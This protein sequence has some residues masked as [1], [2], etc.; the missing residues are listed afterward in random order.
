MKQF[1]LGFIVCLFFSFTAVKTD[2]I[3]FKPAVPT[4]I[5]VDAFG[6]EY[7][8]VEFVKNYSRKG[9]IF[10]QMERTG[11]NYDTRVVVVM[12]KY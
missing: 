9:Y 1:A 4:S 7:D 8:I 10:K 12:E 5:V 6:S 2:L 3:T 11:G